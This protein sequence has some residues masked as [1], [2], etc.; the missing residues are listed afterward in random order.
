MKEQGKKATV[1]Y[2]GGKDS[3]L[4]AAILKLLGYDVEL[5]TASFGLDESYKHAR[6]AASALGFKHRVIKLDEKILAEAA[7]M[8][9][10]D[11]FPNNGMDFLHRK[12]LEEVAKEIALDEG[13]QNNGNREKQVIADGVRRDDKAPKLAIREIR[14][15][16]D[17]YGVSIISPLLGFSYRETSALAK[18]FFEY[19]ENESDK[20]NKGDY[21]S[22]IRKYLKM[23]GWSIEKIFP[24]KHKQSMVISWCTC[25][26]NSASVVRAV[27]PDGTSATV[28][29]C[30][31]RNCASNL[32]SSR[33]K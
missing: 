26:S 22:E 20:I 2:S 13:R 30:E 19:A 11:G 16:E 10:G 9:I 4:A 23:R 6:A 24:K 28:S 14:S 18:S 8:M 17:R 3:S 5:L 7:E 31:R 27:V 12:V 29:W 33:A 32:F 21:E 15:I 1:L 25:A